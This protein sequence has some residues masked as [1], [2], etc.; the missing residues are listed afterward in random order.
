[1]D[2]KR[3]SSVEPT[4]CNSSLQLLDC[5]GVWATALLKKKKINDKRQQI[6]AKLSVRRCVPKKAVSGI[7][8]ELQ[9]LLGL[10]LEDG[11]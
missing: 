10:G 3:L 1:M 4:V 6:S 7:R 11:W 5:F 2:P 8:Q 9:S